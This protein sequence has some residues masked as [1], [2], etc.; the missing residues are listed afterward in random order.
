VADRPDHREI[1]ARIAHIRRLIANLESECG[2]AA[3]LRERFE[4][5]KRE[6]EL[7]LKPARRRSGG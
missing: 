5:M 2:R 7:M 4:H 3:A 1:A 6:I